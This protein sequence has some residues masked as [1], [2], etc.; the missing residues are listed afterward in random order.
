MGVSLGTGGDLVL[1]WGG[2]LRFLL[3]AVVGVIRPFSGYLPLN[4]K[5][6]TKQNYFEL[7]KKILN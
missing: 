3:F 2:G 5:N 4:C 6:I 1:F 7:A